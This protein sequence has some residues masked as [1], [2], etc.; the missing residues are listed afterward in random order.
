MARV[1]TQ[2]NFQKLVD[3]A[4]GNEWDAPPLDKN[5]IQLY[6][7][8][9]PGLIAGNYNVTAEQNIKTISPVYGE[10][11][12]RVYN[13]GTSDTYHAQAQQDDINPQEFEVVAP[14]FSLDKNLVNSYYP[15]DG[16]QDEARIL[17]H[18]VLNDPHLP[19]ERSAGLDFPDPVDPDVVDSR[20]HPTKWYNDKGQV[21]TDSTQARMRSMVPWVCRFLRFFEPC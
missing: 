9:R 21:T 20:D 5:Q 2:T 19:W 16:H 12:Y 7:Y 15:P 18:I 4:A 10:E 13:R 3:K 6:S 1:T 14:Q 8:Y 11:N 17:P